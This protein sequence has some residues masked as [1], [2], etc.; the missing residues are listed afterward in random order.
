MGALDS[1]RGLP[2]DRVATIYIGNHDHSHVAWQAGA[3]DNAGSLQWYR[4][5]PYVISLLTAPGAVL[6][7]NGQEQSRGVLPDGRLAPAR[8]RHR[9]SVDGGI[10]GDLASA[11]SR[12]QL[13][14]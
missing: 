6:I 1:H 10:R 9:F 11:L 12:A 2:D 13:G 3:R 8:S 4:T 14:Q 7:P 5:Q